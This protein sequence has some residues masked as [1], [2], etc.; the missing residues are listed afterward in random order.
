MTTVS[1]ILEKFGQDSVTLLRSNMAKAGQNATGETSSNIQSNMVSDTRVQVSAPDYI[2]V[3]ETGRKPRE[4]SQESNF[5]NKLE[6]WV[7]ARN[8]SFGG[9]L[10]QTVRSLQ[11]LI[12]KRG[13]KLWRQGGRKD[14]ITPILDNKRFIKLTQDILNAEFQRTANTIEN[15][16]NNG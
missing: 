7:Q 11:Y 3:L 16:I 15:T 12:N 4:S 14:I 6:K 9:T 13:T 8:I 1:Q 10:E 5:N 2:Y